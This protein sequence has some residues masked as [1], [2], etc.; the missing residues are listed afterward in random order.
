VVS[1]QANVIGTDGTAIVA[2]ALRAP[3][4]VPDWSRADDAAIIGAATRHRVFLLLGWLLRDAGTLDEWPGL[5]EA[6]ERAEHHALSVDCVRQAELATVLHELDAA[7]VR[8]MLFKGAAVA[9][10]HYPAPHVRVRADSDLL[11]PDGEVRVLEGVLRR[12]GYIRP[13]ET[14]GALV[15]YQSHYQ[16]T[17]RFGVTHAL[18]IHWKVSNLQ[19]LANCLTHAELWH[20][21]VPIVAFGPSAV[22]VDAPHALLLALVHRAGHHP[23][24]KNLLWMYDLYLLD[25]RLSADEHHQFQAIVAARG[26][27]SIVAEGLAAARRSFGDPAR[28]TPVEATQRPSTNGPTRPWTQAEV[29]RLDLEALPGWRTRGRLLREHLLPSSSYMRAK[30]GVRSNVI[31][32]ALYVWRVLHGMPRWLRRPASED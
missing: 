6:L 3:A 29:L 18:D 28:D 15:S 17:D 11:V 22:T 26:L 9:H 27:N 8:P 25:S 23:G 5:S 19:A 12:L 24:S 10:T 16:K 32:P 13:V 20:C 7:G 31:L 4:E 21:R 30:Y 1:S 14:S 2:R